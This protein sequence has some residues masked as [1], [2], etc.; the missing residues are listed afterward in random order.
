MSNKRI[1][2]VVLA[3]NNKHKVKE[4]RAILK[5]ARMKMRILT[6]ADFPP[7]RPVVE[8]RPTLEGNAAKKAKE[9]ARNTGCLA[10]SDDTGLFVKSLK[11]APGVYS[12]RFAGPNCNFLDNNKKLLRLLKGKTGRQR[13]AV[14]R[15]VAAVATP[16]GRVFWVEGKLPGRITTEMKGTHGFGYDPVFEAAGAH[17]TFAELPVS[18]KNKISH[19]ARAFRQV[20]KLMKNAL[21]AL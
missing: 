15:C 9:V 14:F 18:I 12:A 3:T 6:L 8:D 4:I 10:L 11:G 19:R 7:R 16:K 17:K 20:P 1:P 13:S 2:S 21:K 5:K